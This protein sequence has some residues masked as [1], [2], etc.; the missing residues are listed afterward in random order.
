MKRLRL[1]DWMG[2]VLFSLLLGIR[3]RQAADGS[4][5]AFLLAL[6]SGIAA[7]LILTRRPEKQC[8][9][10]YQQATAWLCVV[11]PFSLQGD[12]VCLP[13]TFAGLVFSLWGLISLGQHF[14]IAP[15]DRG[16]VMSGAYRIVRHP[17]YLGE[18]VSYL[19]LGLANIQLVNLVTISVIL[20]LLL[21]RIH[22][23]ER[24]LSGYAHY[25]KLTPWRLIPL[26]W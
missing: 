21:L 10:W 4:W 6:Q 20:I 5:F 2:A 8:A 3:L 16:L 18:L 26:V 9:A 25:Q 23:E 7:A 1:G 24:I 19:G 17:V 22:W 11:L 15:A 13:V 12:R 14:G